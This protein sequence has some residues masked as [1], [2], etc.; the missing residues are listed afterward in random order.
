MR[1]GNTVDVLVDGREALAEMA[2]AIRDARSHIHVSGWH[3]E[4]SFRLERHPDAATV[5][6]LLAERAESVD[7]RV[8]LWAGPPVPVFRPTR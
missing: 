8:L 7:V 1:A 3:L 6:A 4:P 5:Q 2:L